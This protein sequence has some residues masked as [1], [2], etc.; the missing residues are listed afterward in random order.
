[1]FFGYLFIPETVLVN[2]I[3]KCNVLIGLSNL[4]VMFNR[5]QME[6]SKFSSQPV[7]IAGISFFQKALNLVQA[8]QIK[9]QS[10]KQS[11]IAKLT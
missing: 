5:S 1:M 8:F 3:F 7:W 2:Q 9:Y 4:N 11:L 6:H 10:S